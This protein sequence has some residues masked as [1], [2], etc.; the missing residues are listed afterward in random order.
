MSH[1]I[2]T[3][4]FLAAVFSATAIAEDRR[5]DPA[6]DILVTFANEGKGV[7]GTGVSEPYRKRKRYSIDT[8]VRRHAADIASEYVLTEVDRWPIRSLSVF[9]FV[10]RVSSDV[11]R[12]AV[13]ERL[14]ADARV[15]SVQRM[16]QFETLASPRTEYDDTYA[17]L[18][19]GLDVMEIPAAHRY[20]RGQGVRVAIIDSHADAD[21]EDLSGRV[22]ETGFLADDDTSRNVEHGTAIASVIGANA[23]NARGIVG[24]APE[25]VME[26]YVAC[27]AEDGAF[28]AV[29]DSFTLAKALDAL[30]EDAPDVLNLSLTGPYDP[31]LERLLNEVDRAGAV[32]VAAR[33]PYSHKDNQFP[34]SLDRVIS[35]G[36][37]DAPPAARPID[38]ANSPRLREVYAPGEQ[39]MVA[40]PDNAYDFRSGNSLA[41][42]HVSGVIALLLAVS[43]NTPREAIQTYLRMSQ[44]SSR[45]E[46]LSVNA[47]VVLQL[48]DQSRECRG[49]TIRTAVSRSARP[50]LSRAQWY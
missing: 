14:R 32:M 36:S 50:A 6:H 48:L 15:E 49:Q 17:S 46:S 10:Y 2:T 24:V 27:R 12:D 45:A 19:R 7:I 39:I 28:N 9:C 25:S 37:S 22:T 44:R 33:P 40:V 4:V 35:V 29:C 5:P 18:Q 26:L 41:A 23:N 34:A 11:D 30:L 20:S 13:I 38:L 8:E 43:P 42:A 3:V 21:H 1:R 47:C 31:L 16:Q